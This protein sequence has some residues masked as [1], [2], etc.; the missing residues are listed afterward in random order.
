[1]VGK[2]G[3]KSGEKAS[4]EDDQKKRACKKAPIAAS[5][6]DISGSESESDKIKKKTK[7]KVNKKKVNK[8]ES[9]DESEEFDEKPRTSK[10]KPKKTSKKK[11]IELED[12]IAIV[13]DIKDERHPYHRLNGQWLNLN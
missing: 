8:S 5:E 4:K 12:T 13:Y 7:T 9:S 1:M 11:G 3:G 10:K 6:S 2:R